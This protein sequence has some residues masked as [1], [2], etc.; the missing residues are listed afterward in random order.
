MYDLLTL[1]RADDGTWLAPNVIDGEYALI[2]INES[3]GFGRLALT[4][5]PAPPPTPITATIALARQR[6]I[7]GIVVTGDQ[8]AEGQLVM[9]VPHAGTEDGGSP[10]W[11]N[12]LARILL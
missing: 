5:P 12:M 8:P 4:L 11:T 6:D 9:L 2:V 7:A 1:L 10:D 3:V